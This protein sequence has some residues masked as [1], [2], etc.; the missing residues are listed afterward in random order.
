MPFHDGVAGLIGSIYQTK[1]S[2]N[3][4]KSQENFQKRMSN[5]SYQRG[6]R[7][8]KKAGLN[9]ILATKFGGASSPTGAAYSAPNI[10]EAYDQGRS[11]AKSRRLTGE[12]TRLA[13]AQDVRTTAETA[14]TVTQ[15][16][17]L[18]TDLLKAN[19]ELEVLKDIPEIRY[20]QML[21]N[22]DGAT[23]AGATALGFVN[24]LKHNDTNSARDA[25]KKTIPLTQ[26]TIRIRSKKIKL[27]NRRRPNQPS[28]RVNR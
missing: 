24:R 6:V 22:V 18:Q 17:I 9:P 20:L 8:L 16:E 12:Q 14:N 28:R 21:Q 25:Q 15:G 10:G 3:S 26:D 23:A 1:A 11:S 5:T 7:D 27:G 13:S 4:A 19:I 2:Q